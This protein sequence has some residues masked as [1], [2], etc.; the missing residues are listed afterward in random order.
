MLKK[1]HSHVKICLNNKLI[2]LIIKQYIEI[3]LLHY[4]LILSIHHSLKFYLDFE[5]MMKNIGSFIGNLKISNTKK[6]NIDKAF[7]S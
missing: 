4:L 2:R 6:F 5:I 3:L 1:K 7:F